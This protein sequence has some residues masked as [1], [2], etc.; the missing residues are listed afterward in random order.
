MN[1]EKKIE[2]LEKNLTRI[3][4]LIGAADSKSSIIFAIDTAM[5]GV[6]AAV[7]TGPANWS[8]WDVALVAITLILLIASVV[9]L[10]I[11][12][13]PRTEGP[14]DSNIYFGSVANFSKSD[15]EK[16]INSLDSENVK[17]DLVQQC[18]RNSEIA[19]T[20]F[21]CVK[22]SMVLL[23]ISLIPWLLTIYSMYGKVAD[24]TG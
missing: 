2:F 10:S 13:F 3:H 20:K 9:I 17:R 16:R 11:G 22:K 5:L 21:E 19:K 14:E 4:S 6:L 18:Y 23:Y 15:Y 7:L 1:A 12:H 24:G 8:N